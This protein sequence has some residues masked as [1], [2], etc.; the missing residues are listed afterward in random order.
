MLHWCMDREKYGGSYK[1][2]MLPPT[3]QTVFVAYL[4]VQ[5]KAESAI[6]QAA[7]CRLRSR[8]CI[9]LEA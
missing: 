7:I 9:T 2:S 4:S 5:Q 6:K 1:Q 8:Y 3:F